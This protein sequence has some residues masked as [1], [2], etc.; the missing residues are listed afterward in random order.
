MKYLL[1][2]LSFL[3]W[4]V[5]GNAQ[6]TPKPEAVSLAKRAAVL[7]NTNPDSSLILLDQALRIDDSFRQAYLMQS[8]IYT[9]RGAY[10]K[11]IKVMEKAIR[12]K[13]DDYVTVQFLGMLYDKTGKKR[14]AEALYRESVRQ[15]DTLMTTAASPVKASLLLN[16]GTAMVL[17]GDEA[18]ARRDIE[19]SLPMATADMEL[20]DFLKKTIDTFTFDKH[21]MLERVFPAQQK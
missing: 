1:I 9:R 17:L 7:S 6:T 12:L 16:R 21:Q 4:T 2:L 10:D 11:A 15:I 13:K 20:Y 19:L 3:A 14:K 8:G 18:A 5:P